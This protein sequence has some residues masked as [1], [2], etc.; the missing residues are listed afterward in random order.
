MGK[1]DGRRPTAISEAEFE[2]NVNRIFGERKRTPYVPPP[3]K[4]LPCPATL[5][6]DVP[7]GEPIRCRKDEKHA[8]LHEG[9]VLGRKFRWTD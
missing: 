2:Q 3:L 7:G 9:S 6:P 1:G 8:G 4:I 5:A